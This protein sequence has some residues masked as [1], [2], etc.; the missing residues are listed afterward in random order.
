MQN[1]CFK[2]IKISTLFTVSV[3]VLLS[4]FMLTG[5]CLK[6]SNAV[7]S[8]QQ[9]LERYFFF[10]LNNKFIKLNQKEKEQE[11][12][13]AKWI[14]IEI[15]SKI[16]RWFSFYR[17]SIDLLFFFFKLMQWWYKLQSRYHKSFPENWF[18]MVTLLRFT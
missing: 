18:W 11:N 3:C 6:Y 7:Y 10:Y 16:W 8:K 2:T 4:F 1:S 17:G 14:D 5:L 13:S 12:F 9:M 15:W